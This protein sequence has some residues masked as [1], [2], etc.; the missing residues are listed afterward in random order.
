MSMSNTLE[1]LILDYLFRSSATFTKPADIAIA[2]ATGAIGEAET[3]AI[4]NEVPNS[5][6]YARQ[7]LSP[8]DGNWKDPSTSTQGVVNN[9]SDITFGPASGGNWGT[10][11]HVAILDST[12]HGGGNLLFYGQLNTAKAVNNGDTFK[13][14]AGNL[15]I[16]LN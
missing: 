1:E 6:G 14:N 16:Q 3:G 2:L 4:T 11:T 13:F 15:N 9:L 10:I 12:T 5:N 8:N 7:S